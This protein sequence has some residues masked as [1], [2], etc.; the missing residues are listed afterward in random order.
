[1]LICCIINRKESWLFLYISD[2][3]V[4]VGILLGKLEMFIGIFCF[5]GGL[6]YKEKLKL[7]F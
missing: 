3:V 5:N 6:L 7:Y 4:N 2:I 1:M